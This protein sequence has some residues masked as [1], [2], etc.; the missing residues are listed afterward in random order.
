MVAHDKLNANKLKKKTKNIGSQDL[1]VEGSPLSW[2]DPE[3]EP[4]REKPKLCCLLA[5]RVSGFLFFI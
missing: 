3:M 1:K 5:V 2:L 4:C